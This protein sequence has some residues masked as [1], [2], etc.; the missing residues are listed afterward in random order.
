[1]YTVNLSMVMMLTKWA[2]KMPTRIQTSMVPVLSQSQSQAF[3]RSVNYAPDGCAIHTVLS[4][5]TRYRKHVLRKSQ[6]I[7]PLANRHNCQEAAAVRLT[8][9]THLSYHTISILEDPHMHEAI[10]TTATPVL[11]LFGLRQ[12]HFSVR[13]RRCKMNA[14]AHR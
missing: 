7:L 8:I 13:P 12:S 14:L 11:G 3:C 4:N 9:G 5:G 2:I 6:A 1:M 10:H